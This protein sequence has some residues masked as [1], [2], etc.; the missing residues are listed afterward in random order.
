MNSTS[1]TLPGAEP[2][3]TLPPAAWPLLA[4]RFLLSSVSSSGSFHSFVLIIFE[5]GKKHIALI[6][7]SKTFM[8]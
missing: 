2:L 4:A 1:F 8:L 5:T 7:P 3:S 6:F